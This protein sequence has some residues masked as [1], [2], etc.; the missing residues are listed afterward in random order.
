MLIRYSLKNFQSFRDSAEVDLSLNRKIKKLGWETRTKGGR[1]ISTALGVIGPNGAGKTAL[2]KPIVFAGWFINSSFHA[3]ADARIP[4]APHF[5]TPDAPTELEFEAEDSDGRLWRYVLHVTPERV[6]H[7]AIHKKHERFRYL[8]VRDWIAESA[9]YSIKLQDFDFA[10]KEA[11][12]VRQ[13][14]S[15]ISTAAQY[16]VEIARHLASVAIQSNI[17]YQGRLPFRNDDLQNA[18]RHFATNQLQRDEMTRLLRSWDLGLSDVEL[19]ELPIQ[20]P[21]QS[22]QKIWYPIGIHASR[23]N[24]RNALMFHDES[25]GTQSAF[26]LLARLLH[27]LFLGGMAVIDEFESDLHPHMIEPVLD[28]FANPRTNPHGAQL[29]FTCHAAEVL[30]LLH[31]SQIM[32]VEKNEKCESAAWRMDS[33]DGIR[34]DDDYYSKYMAGAYGAVPRV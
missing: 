26:V 9:T 13:N 21:G 5:S 34:S 22:P 1:R 12:K 6:I 28:L 27:T 18:A 31:K 29:L 16:G 11:K 15:L 2:L 3:S 32:L 23:D 14:A 17:N 20:S 4:I 25:S 19:N 30:N 8:F 7:E 10:P 24:S 33:V